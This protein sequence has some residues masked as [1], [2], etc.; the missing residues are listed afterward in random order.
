[1]YKAPESDVNL[2]YL[3]LK[4]KYYIATNESISI[5]CTKDYKYTFTKGRL[6]YQLYEENTKTYVTGNLKINNLLGVNDSPYVTLETLEEYV[7]ANMSVDVD[8]SNYY[9]KEE[10]DNGFVVNDTSFVFTEGTITSKEWKGICYGNNLFV[11]VGYEAC[12]WSQDGKI[13]NNGTISSNEWESVCYGNGLFV[14]VGLGAC[15]WSEDGKKFTKGNI[16]DDDE[17]IWFGICY[18]NNLFVAIGTES[19]AWSV[20]GKSFSKGT[21][22]PYSWNDICYGNGLFVAVGLAAW[23]WSE[24]G[25]IFHEVTISSGIVLNSICYGNG[26]FVAFGDYKQA[27]WSK[28]GKTFTGGLCCCIFRR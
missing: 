4:K 26:L 10:V 23:A 7:L 28:D 21:I 2:I 12:A 15:A 14:A 25:K 5:T 17:E 24:D 11:A 20:D 16:L 13:F 9:T 6:V 27:F 8:L 3:D 19:C 22:S 18:G 1:M